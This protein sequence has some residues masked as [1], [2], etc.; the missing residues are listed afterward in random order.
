MNGN[1]SDTAAVTSMTKASVTV[2]IRPN[3]EANSSI[4]AVAITLPD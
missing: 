2:R 1:A 4:A 3:G